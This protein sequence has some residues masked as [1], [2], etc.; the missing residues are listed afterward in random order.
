MPGL[1]VPVP[2]RP[3]PVTFLRRLPSACVCAGCWSIHATA[4]RLPCGH[5]LCEPC[6]DVAFSIRPKR[7]ALPDQETVEETRNG[8]CV[9]D[10]DPF[11][12]LDVQLLDFSREAM[13]REMVICPNAEFGCRF[14]ASCRD[15][16]DLNATSTMQAETRRC[17]KRPR[18]P[19]R[20]VLKSPQL[21]SSSYQLRGFGSPFL[22]SVP[23]T[24]LR[25]LPSACVCAGCQSIHAT[26][27]R[28]P[29][30]HTLCEPCRDVAFSIQPK[31]A[32]LPGQKT[33][34]GTRNGTC[35]IDGDPFSSLDLQLLDFS[36][37][38]MY[39]EMV[40]CPNAEFGCRFRGEL[41]YLE[42]HCLDKCRRVG[43]NVSLADCVPQLSP[44][45]R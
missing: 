31:R 23:V 19:S 41:R 25:Q 6:R 4:A 38:A 45:F 11:S 3:V 24:F 22:D 1:R 9:I 30:G 8:T 43:I 21:S 20:R 15:Q 10:G 28:L 17:G 27:A 39:R 26:A 44:A 34:E 7:A 5:T 12:S 16:H 35:V 37:E 2:G 40:I 18:S 14:R 13:Y 32:A 33:V 36:R 29:C 42:Q